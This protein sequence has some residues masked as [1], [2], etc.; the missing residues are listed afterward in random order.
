MKGGKIFAELPVYTVFKLLEGEPT[1]FK[2][3]FS[4]F[5]DEL[6]MFYNPSMLERL[7]DVDLQDLPAQL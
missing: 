2:K 1:L 5:K 3:M 7:R 4:P 6:Y